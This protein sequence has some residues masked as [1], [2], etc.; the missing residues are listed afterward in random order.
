MDKQKRIITFV[1]CVVRSFHV[2]YINFEKQIKNY[3]WFTFILMNLNEHC[4]KSLKVWS[5]LITKTLSIYFNKAYFQKND[6]HTDLMGISV[7][8]KISCFLLH[9]FLLFVVNFFVV[10]GCLSTL[11]S[12]IVQQKSKVWKNGW[13]AF[14]SIQY[15]N[16]DRKRL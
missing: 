13:Y 7:I 3:I 2:F 15:T 5:T 14:H 10:R 11:L 12:F 16:S 4:H 9:F 8:K 1:R 6:D